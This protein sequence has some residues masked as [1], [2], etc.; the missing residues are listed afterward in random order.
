MLKNLMVK[1]GMVI[2]TKSSLIEKK[3]NERLSWLKEKDN[4]YLIKKLQELV[5]CEAENAG[6][7]SKEKIKEQKITGWISAPSIL[8]DPELCIR[9]GSCVDTC[10]TIQTAEAIVLDKEKGIILD[11]S[12]CVR[13]GQCIHACPMGKEINA[14]K[15][16]KKAFGCETCAY[17]RPLGAIREIDQV[18]EVINVLQDPEKFVVVEFAPSIRASLGEEFGLEPGSL[19]T[20]KLY[21]ALRKAGFDK[22]W[23]TNFTADLTII[24]EGTELI[25]RLIKAGILSKDE[26]PP[27]LNINEHAIEEV[28][29]ALPQFTSCSPG[30]VKF[31]E[32]FYPELIPNISSAKSPQQMLGPIAKTYA[33]KKL[34]IDPKKMVVVSI[35]PCTAK[36]YEREREEMCDA[37][38]YWQEKGEV[39]NKFQDVDYVLT[40]RECAKLLK[41]LGIDLKKMPEEEA[42]PLI[43]KYTGAATIFGRTGGVMEAA[44]RTA[45]ELITGTPLEKLEFEDLGSLEGIKKASIKLGNKEI[46]VAVAH[47]LSNARKIC[48]SIKQGNG[49][50][51]YVFIEFMACPGGCI[52]GGGQPIPTNPTT[53]KTRTTALNTDDKKCALRKSHENPEVKQVYSDFLKE[54]VSKLA[55][56]LLHTQYI[57]RSKK[58]VS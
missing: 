17:S 35:M 25:L 4:C 56:H 42:D 44:L 50:K 6:L 39:N 30:W 12:K 10:K 49:F 54:P 5:I 22:V 16:F 2:K 52:G 48:E 31:C 34:G 26:L 57:D 21:A 41:I 40:T 51:D 3:L 29:S 24:E 55:H 13:C 20:H 37:F 8:Y 28:S 53:V 36:K 19:V 15:V 23:D 58:E 9:C 18:Q 45:Y 11:E 38:K 14:V 43:G 7:I 27:D 33:A 47:G 32:T 1:E 46:K